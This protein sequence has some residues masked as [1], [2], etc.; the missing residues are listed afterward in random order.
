M[1]FIGEHTE[2]IELQKRTLTYNDFN[3][4]IQTWVKDRDLYAEFFEQQGKEGQSD[5]QI[6]AIQ[7]TRCKIRYIHGLN[8]RDF[9]IKRGDDIYDIQSIVRAG[10]NKEQRLIL[11]WRDNE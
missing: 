10:R 9:R 6:L 2:K 7:D 4:E 1:R 8:K 11:E 5:G 3:E